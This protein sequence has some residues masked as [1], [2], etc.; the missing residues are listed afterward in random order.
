MKK[1][2]LHIGLHKTGSTFLQELIFKKICKDYNLK[3]NLNNQKISHEINN[4]ISLFRNN[5]D[6][7]KSLSMIDIDYG[8]ISN[9]SL[10][11]PRSDPAFFQYFQTFAALSK[12][13]CKVCFRYGA[14]GWAPAKNTEKSE[15]TENCGSEPWGVEH[16]PRATSAHA[17]RK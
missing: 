15:N 14:G 11:G 9:E 8:V 6:C 17:S 16:C 2:L 4:K 7:L 5:F 10:C 3:S 1:L 13:H 12:K